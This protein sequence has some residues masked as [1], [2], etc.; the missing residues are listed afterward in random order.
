MLPALPKRV[1][2]DLTKILLSGL[3]GLRC[4]A[5]V[6]ALCVVT[7]VCVLHMQVVTVF[8]YLAQPPKTL[9]GKEL[10][11]YNQIKLWYRAQE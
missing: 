11:T 3:V 7:C 2:R 6:K 1:L 8:Q 4:W 5:C 10:P 9:K